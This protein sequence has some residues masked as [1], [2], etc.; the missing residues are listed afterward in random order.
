MP[1]DLPIIKTRTDADKIAKMKVIAEFNHRSLSKEVE[2]LIDKHIEEFEK[3]YGILE[4]GY[5][6]PKEVVADLKK[7]ILGQPPYGN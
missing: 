7:R 2:S 5:M 1:S 4:I 6:S 3:E